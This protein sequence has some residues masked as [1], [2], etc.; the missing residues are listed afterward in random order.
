MALLVRLQ[1]LLDRCGVAYTH[2][3]HPLAYTAR[4]VAAAEQLPAQEVAKVVVFLA[5]NGYRMV[6]LPANKVVDFQE[7]RAMLG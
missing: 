5:E 1:E 6:V 3:V 4:E 7:L 2:T